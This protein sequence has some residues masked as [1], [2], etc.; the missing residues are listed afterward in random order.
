MY[1]CFG[2]MVSVLM[3]YSYDGVDDNKVINCLLKA[4][5]IGEDL[6]SENT[7]K[8]KRCII[9][10]PPEIAEKARK[11]CLGK[12]IK[13]VGKSLAE[14]LPIY[15]NTDNKKEE[16]VK[17]F[18][19][20]IKNSENI[21]NIICGCE[22][23]SL[24]RQQDYDIFQFLATLLLYATG[25]TKNREGKNSLKILDDSF[26]REIE[27]SSIKIN[28]GSHISGTDNVL[29]FTLDENSFN[30]VFSEIDLPCGLMDKW[31]VRFFCLSMNNGRFDYTGLCSYFDMIIGGYVF[32]RITI[33]GLGKNDSAL[34]VKAMRVFKKAEKARIADCK[35]GEILS[36]QMGDIILYAF[37]E[38]VLKAPK[39]MSLVE[40]QQKKDM[41]VRSHGTHLLRLPNGK[42][43]LVVAVS[44]IC[45][46][47][48]EG[49]KRAIDEIQ[50]IKQHFNEYRRIASPSSLR[51]MVDSQTMECIEYSFSL[52]DIRKSRNLS[53]SFG[54]FIGFDAPEDLND[55]N[56]KET[57]KKVVMDLIPSIKM[58]LDENDFKRFPIYIYLMP[59]NDAILDEQR[60]MEN[61]IE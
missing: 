37:L 27:A 39:I 23:E 48:L 19:E 35:S 26:F 32:D 4:L 9:N 1:F 14:S 17:S 30:S 59:F 5:E 6:D 58:Q 44:A 55:G 29:S 61:F 41:S 46:A 56:Y 34:G 20:I 36:S 47:L 25:Y 7:S 28:L 18:L 8:L 31:D 12:R 42:Y 24:L 52:T 22:K 15:V 10:F 16:I 3:N 40:F 11:I 2:V 54:V 38:N 49:M 57:L 60:I 50:Y 43:Q 33:S 21:E 53:N 51:G 13:G 45:K